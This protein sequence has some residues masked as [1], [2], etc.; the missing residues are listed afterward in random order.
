[1]IAIAAGRYWRQADAASQT[2]LVDAFRRFSTATY[3]ARFDGYSGERF[4]LL[5][6]DDGPRKTQIVRTR[7]VGAGEKKPVSLSYVL[8][9]GAAGWRVADVL[10]DAGISELAV[11]RSEYAA[12]LQRDGVDG[13]VRLLTEKADRLLTP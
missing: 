6:V 9:G 3:A 1:M 12:V 4:E 13:L 8:R 2:R 11:R 10:L 5:G 7:I